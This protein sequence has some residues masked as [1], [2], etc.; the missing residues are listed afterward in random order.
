MVRQINVEV[1][2]SVFFLKRFLSSVS[3]K[4]QTKVFGNEAMMKDAI[5]N[6][7]LYQLLLTCNKM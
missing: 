5:S 2:K 7:R 3:S 4:T 1:K 6:N